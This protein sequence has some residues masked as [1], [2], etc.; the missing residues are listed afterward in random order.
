MQNNVYEVLGCLYRSIDDLFAM[1]SAENVLV[2]KLQE[3]GHSTGVIHDVLDWT[4]DFADI[5]LS[6]ENRSINSMGAY[7]VFTVN[8]MNRTTSQGRSFI[9]GLYQSRVIDIGFIELILSK[10]ME[11]VEVADQHLMKLVMLI[12]AK[13]VKKNAGLCKVT[14][15]YEKILYFLYRADKEYETHVH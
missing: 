14:G 11:I 13:L 6:L 3:L 15:A 1:E 9:L 10:S 12:F 8:E 2:S 4:Y 5:V 7:R